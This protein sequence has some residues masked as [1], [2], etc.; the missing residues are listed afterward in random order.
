MLFENYKKLLRFQFDFSPSKEKADTGYDT[1]I[2]LLSQRLGELRVFAPKYFSSPQN[3]CL[4]YLC[5]YLGYAISRNSKVLIINP[6]SFLDLIIAQNSDLP[7]QI[8]IASMNGENQDRLALMR[9][10]IEFY[11]QKNFLDTSYFNWRSKFDI[12]SIFKDQAYV[13]LDTT[14]IT[15]DDFLALI[16]E[17]ANTKTKPIIVRSSFNYIFDVYR[18]V[19]LPIKF[20]LFPMLDLPNCDENIFYLKF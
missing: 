15:T 10:R 18:N 11:S 16:L 19:N 17:F 14:N 20:Q 12:C 6:Q 3:L 4:Y 8:T 7:V 1:I 9:K 5:S 2:C 13:F